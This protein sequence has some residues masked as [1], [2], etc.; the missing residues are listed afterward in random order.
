MEVSGFKDTIRWY[1]ENAV[2]Y[3]QATEMSAQKDELELFASLL[4]SGDEILDAG[5]G[6]GRDTQALERAGFPTTGI[7]ISGG[8]IT[9]AKRSFPEGKFVEGSFLDLPFRSEQFGG[10]WANASLLHLQTVEDVRRSFR[11]F[12]RVLKNDGIL[13]VSVKAQTGDK[14]TA[15]VSDKLSGHDRFFQ[16]FTLE[17]INLLLEE[18]GFEVIVSEQYNE[19]SKS[20]DGRSEVEWLHLVGRKV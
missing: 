14:K 7:D 1:D 13:H 10:V 9:E 4:K 16:Y 5:C 20:P 8:L 12:C 17:E 6:G 11:E 18:S 2:K 19:A 3:A 15:V